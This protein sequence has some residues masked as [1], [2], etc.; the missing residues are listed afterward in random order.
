AVPASPAPPAL[1]PHPPRKISADEFLRPVASGQTQRNLS[2]LAIQVQVE[3]EEGTAQTFCVDPFRD[4]L[5][6]GTIA[7]EHELVAGRQFVH[8][9]TTRGEEAADRLF[10][11]ALGLRQR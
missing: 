4:E 11:I 8:R 10:P 7:G 9:E 2:A 3:L 6:R 5:E 1:L